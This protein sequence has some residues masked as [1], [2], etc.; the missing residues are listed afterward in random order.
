MCVAEPACT[1]MNRMME[2]AKECANKFQVVEAHLTSTKVSDLP[3]EKH[4]EL[5]FPKKD[6]TDVVINGFLQV[7]NET[8][9]Y[10][11]DAVHRINAKCAMNIRLEPKVRRDYRDVSHSYPY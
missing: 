7:V 8:A 11:E 6:K 1:S 3:K 5:N 2:K 10:V 4:V 9:T